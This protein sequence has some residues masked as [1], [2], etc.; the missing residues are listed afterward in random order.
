[1]AN[2]FID[3]DNVENVTFPSTLKT[4]GHK[5]FFGCE[6]LSTLVFKSQKAPALLGLEG[7]NGA[8]ANFVD[9]I[10]VLETELTI[11]TPDD[12]SYRTYIWVKYFANRQ[13]AA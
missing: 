8:Y 5:A 1:M 7:E 2:A 11:Y 10:N 4:I 6:N 13:I 12:A 3:N 9:Y